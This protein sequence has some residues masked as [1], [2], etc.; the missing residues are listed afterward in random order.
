MIYIQQL[1]SIITA[2]GWSQEELARELK[3]SFP[4][5][6]A[7]LNERATPRQGAQDRI[8]SLYESILGVITVDSQEL[9]RAKQSADKLSYSVRTLL[10][11]KKA[12][13][14]LTL[15][16]TYHTN[17]IEGS[18]MTLADVED[19]IF[20]HKV[21]ANRT[22]IE[23][24]EARNHQAAL[25]WLLDR[26]AE[27]GKAFTL[28]EQLILD[29]HVRLMNGIISNA[30]Q[31]RNHSVRIMGT[32]VALANWQRIPELV[33]ELVTEARTESGED[34]VTRLARFH[35]RFEK[36]HPFSDGNGRTGRLLLLAQAF[37]A[38]IIPPLVLRERKQAYYKY[39]EAAQKNENY[40]PLELF[41]AQ[42]M[43]VC[44]ELLVIPQKVR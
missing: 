40:E 12:L 13:D 34:I 10:E 38:N 8:T 26:I 16:L 22:L 42:A 30:G 43:Q 35:A 24:A 20:D 4:A 33:Q 25:H 17:T 1:K 32:H 44:Y 31:Y 23:Q 5:L 39:L 36:I 19:V 27:A 15:Y 21:L 11:D 18:T 2:T 29:L 14:T 41:L 3:V 37:S 7:W 28:D 6:N 9:V